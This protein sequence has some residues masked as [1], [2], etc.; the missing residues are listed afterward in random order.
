M[1][2]VKAIGSVQEALALIDAHHGEAEDFTLAVPD[3]LQDPTGMNMA[4]ITDR[5]LARGWQPDGYTS[6]PGIRLYRYKPLE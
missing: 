2:T 1:N 4:L 5:I 6:Q 3:S